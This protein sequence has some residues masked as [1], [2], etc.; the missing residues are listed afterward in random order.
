MPAKGSPII[1]T[2]RFARP[3]A[4]K[5]PGNPKSREAADRG[6]GAVRSLTRATTLVGR[7]EIGLM[8]DPRFTIDAGA[9]DDVI[10]RAGCPSSWR[11]VRP[12][13]VIPVPLCGL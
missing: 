7:T 1:Q 12:Y 10:V 2:G 6:T 3:R 8:D 11:R 4:Y 13:R 5:A 9:F